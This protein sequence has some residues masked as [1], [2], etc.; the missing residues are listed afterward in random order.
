M[1]IA[2]AQRLDDCVLHACTSLNDGGS[3][4]LACD[5]RWPITDHYAVFP[6]DGRPA[7]KPCAYCDAA[8][9]EEQKNLIGLHD[10]VRAAPSSNISRAVQGFILKLEQFNKADVRGFMR[11]I[12]PCEHGR[13]PITRC[14]EG[15]APRGT[16]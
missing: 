11:W 9:H 14:T 13:S 7:D 2:W 4:K 16:T 6:V 1:I 3:V 10:I 8:W 12:G 5:G 15:C